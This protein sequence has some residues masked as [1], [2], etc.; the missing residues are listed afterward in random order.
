MPAIELVETPAPL[1][2]IVSEPEGPYRSRDAVTFATNVSALPGTVLGAV[3]VPGL[4]TISAVADADNVGNGTLTPDATAPIA[5]VAKNGA[6]RVVFTSATAFVVSDPAGVE[7]G[8]GAVGTAFSKD[9]KFVIAAGGTAFSA[10]DAF[11]VLVG[12]E[13]ITD[14]LYAPLNLADT[15]GLAVAKAIAGFRVVTTTA[16][17]KSTVFN[18]PGEV[19]ASDLIWPAGITAAQKAAAVQQLRALGIKPR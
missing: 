19:R 15:N 10:N 14:E 17:A 12:R 4:E 16:T 8:K 13:A 18:G 3:G 6:Y 9:V 2:F 1:T 7:I 5:A 11:N